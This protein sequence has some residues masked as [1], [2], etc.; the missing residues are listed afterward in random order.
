MA[1][2]RKLIRTDEGLVFTS[3]LPPPPYTPHVSTPA[4]A[5]SAPSAPAPFPPVPPSSP[6]AALAGHP[7]PRAVTGPSDIHVG[8]G[9]RWF[10]WHAPQ[11]RQGPTDALANWA[12][13]ARAEVGWI[14]TQRRSPDNTVVHAVTPILSCVKGH[15]LKDDRGEVLNFP[16]D[17]MRQITEAVDNW[18]YRHRQY[19][20]LIDYTTHVWGP[21]QSYRVSL[22][23]RYRLVQCP[24]DDCSG[25]GSSVRAAKA[26]AAERLLRS[27]HCMIY[28]PG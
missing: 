19:C 25:I 4:A 9:S 6:A 11:S 16:Y 27:G 17:D 1:G 8:G 18:E 5:P 13:R 24:I 7:P 15:V 12:A 22:M 23:I 21:A 3:D 10:H 20:Q 28:I 2:I 26:D 14:A